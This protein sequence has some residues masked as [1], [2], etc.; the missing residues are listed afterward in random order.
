MII[1]KRIVCFHLFVMTMLITTSVQAGIQLNGTRVIYPANEREV[2]LSMINDGSEA[3]LVQSWVD[4][5]D[6]RERPED[7]KAP[8]IITPPMTRV[9]PGKGQT[10]R[11]IF[12]GATLPQDR[13][14][15]FWLNVLEIPPKPVKKYNDESENY[16][17]MAVRSRI[18]I[19]YRP[20]NL[21]DTPDAAVDKL[22]WR[23]IS[24]KGSSAVMKCINM[25]PYNVSFS[26][27]S[28]KNAPV[29]RNV[30]KGGMCP[31]K[32]EHDFSIS[33]DHLKSE[34]KLTLMSIND[35]GAFVNHIVNFSK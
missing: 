12:S 15:V 24:V 11:I 16:V 10:L 31:A 20:Q 18:K 5:G 13:E 26:D 23:L 19:F 4:S 1:V 35:Y 30:S 8:F 14:S 33:G 22:T 25:T 34:G 28:F 29:N 17:Q 27:V 9:D 32:S 21:P 7:S 3:R 2:S 6:V